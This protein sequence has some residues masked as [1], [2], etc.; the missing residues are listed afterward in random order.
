MPEYRGHGLARSLIEAITH[1]AAGHHKTLTLN[2]G[3]LSAR[4][5]YEH[6]G[7]TPVTHPGITHIRR[8]TQEDAPA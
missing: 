6:L 2:V 1:I 8:L 5:F 4:G 7:F 3:E